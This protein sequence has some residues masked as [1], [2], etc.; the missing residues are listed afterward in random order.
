MRAYSDIPHDME[1]EIRWD[2]AIGSRHIGVGVRNRVVNPDRHGAQLHGAPSSRTGRRARGRRRVEAE[3]GRVI[4]RASVRTPAE[5][6][7]AERA[8]W[9]APGATWVENRL[10][11]RVPPMSA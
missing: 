5:R 4:L 8:A 9:R 1:L 2:P 11:V 6:E 7:D 10:G 3:G